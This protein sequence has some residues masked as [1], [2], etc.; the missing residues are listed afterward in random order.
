MKKRC[1]R[2]LLCAAL[3]VVACMAAQVQ[4][5]VCDRGT[6]RDY[7]EECPACGNEVCTLYAAVSV[8]WWKSVKASSPAER[9]A[10][11]EEPHAASF[12]ARISCHPSIAATESARCAAARTATTT[13]RPGSGGSLASWCAAGTLR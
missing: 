4:A 12:T 7:R 11:R 5:Q 2:A 13:R 6:V 9:S 8:N 10:D 1:H 3:A